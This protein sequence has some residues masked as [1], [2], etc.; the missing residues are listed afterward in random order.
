MSAD[1]QTLNNATLRL[2][3]PDLHAGNWVRHALDFLTAIISADM[4]N[5]GSLNPTLGTMQVATTCDRSHWATAVAGFGEFMR[6]YEYFNFDPT[7]NEGRPFFR[8][9]FISGRQFR[10]TDIYSE[11][12]RI[13][14][15]MDHAAV[16]VPTD[17]GCWTWF[18]V[19][20]GGSKDFNDRDRLLLT[21]A[22]QHLTN[23]R[24]LAMAR[25]KV[26]DEF[27]FDASTFTH[28]GFTLRESEVA[29]WLIEGKTNPEIATLMKCQPQT[30]KSHIT[31]LFNKTGTSN[32]LALTLHV[33][34]LIRTVLR[35][36]NEIKSF[37]VKDWQTS[38]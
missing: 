26:R 28:A 27:P 18:A 20:R 9:E 4:V 31:A 12:F 38:H 34:E 37:P 36:R 7:V 24:Q 21:L 13:L 22:Q 23:S 14:E 11:C 1:L 15:T 2:Y 25:Q 8:S 29:Y 5:Y 3:S 16:H 32:R 17:D 6:K 33:M 10:E 19:E 30:V 35:T